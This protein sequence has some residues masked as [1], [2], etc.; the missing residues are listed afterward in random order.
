MQLYKVQ[1]GDNLA[2]IA[3]RFGL[4]VASLKRINGLNSDLIFPGQD[5]QIN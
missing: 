5:L 1:R 3:R 4:T 2:A